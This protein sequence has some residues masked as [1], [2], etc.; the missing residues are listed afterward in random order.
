MDKH[1]S[2]SNIPVHVCSIE[3]N[4]HQ[5]IEVPYSYLFPDDQA[6]S[7]SGLHFFSSY[8]SCTYFPDNEGAKPSEKL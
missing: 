5:E 1:C 3:K 4:D 7:P 6:Q 8:N 2:P